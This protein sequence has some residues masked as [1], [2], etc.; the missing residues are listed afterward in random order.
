MS[1]WFSGKISANKISALVFATDTWL[2]IVTK[3]V[4]VAKLSVAPDHDASY[5]LSLLSPNC[6][7]TNNSI[8]S[9]AGAGL[10]CTMDT[11]TNLLQAGTTTLQTLNNQSNALS[12]LSNGPDPTLAYLTVNPS[13]R[14]QQH[15]FSAATYGMRTSC[16]PITRS[17]NMNTEG[18]LA[19]WNCSNGVFAQAASNK[20]SLTIQQMFFD[21]ETMT[22]P[23]DGGASV[24]PSYFVFASLTQLSANPSTNLVSDPEVVSGSGALAAILLCSVGFYDTTYDVVE[25]NV[26]HMSS[27]LSNVSVANVFIPALSESGFGYPNMANAFNMAA[28]VAATAQDLSDQFALAYSKIALCIG[29]GSVVRTPALAAQTRATILVARVPKAPLFLLMVINLIFVVLG[30]ALAVDAARSS[31][32]AH[33]VQS[34][35]SIAGLVAGMFEKETMK[36]G[37]SDRLVLGKVERLFREYYEGGATKRVGIA[38]GQDGELEFKALEKELYGDGGVGSAYGGWN[39]R[40]MLG[41][42]KPS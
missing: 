31:P 1:P 19:T 16:R 23:S 17:C 11:G 10:V 6:T 12:V 22:Q 28:S 32:E 21:D 2:H 14:D 18:G 41:H 3:T 9:Q 8:A 42:H 36:T 5:G 25:G 7:M 40:F 24:N 4:S 37:P 27:I 20:A 26:T 38:R 13:D 35:F 15:D 29:A 34:R 33:E 30:I 39:G